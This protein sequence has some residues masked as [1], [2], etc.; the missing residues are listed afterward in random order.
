MDACFSGGFITNNESLDAIHP[1]YVTGFS[2]STYVS[3]LRAFADIGELLGKNAETQ[4]RTAP[5]VLAAAGSAEYSYEDTY[6]QGL[7][8]ELRNGVF[9]YFLLESAQRGDRNGDGF[10]TTTEAYTYAARAIDRYWNSYGGSNFH[11]HISGGLK[12]LVL[13][14]F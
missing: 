9:T 10:V 4:G 13:F 5:I 6:H 8:L 7:E 12:D 3:P 14:G 1:E 2:P 11:P